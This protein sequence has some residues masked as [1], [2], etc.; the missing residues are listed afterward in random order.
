MDIIATITANPAGA[1]ATTAATF[2]LADFLTAV[3]AA[4]RNGTFRVAHVNDWV[5]SHLLGRVM[6][7]AGLA[8]LGHF[9]GIDALFAIAGLALATY[10]A[11]TAVSIRDNLG[12]PSVDHG[13]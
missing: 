4:T 8:A 13:R 10:L 7:I 2:A 11:E 12:L 9:V 5:A 1:I 3:G 6:P